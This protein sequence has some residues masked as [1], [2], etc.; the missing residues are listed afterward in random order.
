M[1]FALGD[2]LA[3]V[4]MG[5]SGSCA[6]RCGR[7]VSISALVPINLKIVLAMGD[8]FAM[9]PH[10][11][12]AQAP[13]RLCAPSSYTHC[14]FRTPPPDIAFTALTAALTAALDRTHRIGTATTLPLRGPENIRS[15]FLIPDRGASPMAVVH[16]LHA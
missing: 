13:F 1:A 7:D 6:R 9:E 8:L 12:A 5:R 3:A 16:I 11:L 2:V 14:A 10:M 15:R 4:Q